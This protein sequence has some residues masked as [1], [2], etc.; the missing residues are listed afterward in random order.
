MAQFDV[1]INPSPRSRGAYPLVLLMQS[2]W[3][4][5]GR[6]QIIAPLTRRTEFAGA[7]QRLS[8]IVNLDGLEYAV[9]VPALAVVRYRDLKALVGSVASARN[10]LLAA[11][12]YLFFGL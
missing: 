11:I 5:D 6:E 7:G 8:P 2:A 12:D 4:T 10:A 9:L 1:F 3:A